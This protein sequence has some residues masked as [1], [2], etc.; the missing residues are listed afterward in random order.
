M[1]SAVLII[2]I[3]TSASGIYSCYKIPKHLKG[4]ASV[5]SAEKYKAIQVCARSAAFSLLGTVIVCIFELVK[6]HVSVAL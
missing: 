5:C 1:N 3:L 6:R 4:I 2:I